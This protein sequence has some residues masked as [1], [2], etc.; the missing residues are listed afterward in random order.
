M[1]K[2]A[3]SALK[4]KPPP[5]RF[6][7][8][9][10][11]SCSTLTTSAASFS[12]D[13]LRPVRWTAIPPPLIVLGHKPP[14]SWYHF[15]CTC[16]PPLPLLLPL[17]SRPA[18]FPHKLVP[19]TPFAVTFG[20]TILCPA[21]KDSSR[22]GRPAPSSA[23]VPGPHPPYTLN[24]L[25]RLASRSSLFPLHRGEMPSHVRMESLAALSFIGGDS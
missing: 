13:S 10:S 5:K 24:S 12:L 20:S 23:C 1:G 15:G 14:F 9:P 19:A 2:Q 4:C 8:R 21:S 6:L 16:V 22:V 3:S 7:R 18:L 25:R 11:Y 17:L